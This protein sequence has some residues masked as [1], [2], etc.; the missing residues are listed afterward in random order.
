MAAS[1]SRQHTYVSKWATFS[2]TIIVMLSSG[3]NY[4]FSMW[5]G[6]VQQQMGYSSEQLAGLATACSIG[7]YLNILPG[8][9]YDSVRGHSRLGPRLTLAVGVL[10]QFG[11]FLGLWLAASNAF[12]PPYWVMWLMAVAACNCGPWF[13]TATM[14]TCVRNFEA[15][16]GIIISICKACLGLS[17]AFY[18]TLYQATYAPDA[19]NFILL[20]AMVPT[21]S[22]LL[23]LPFINYVPFVPVDST[24]SLG[25]FSIAYTSIGALVMYQLLDNLE[26]QQMPWR[27]HAWLR[28]PALAFLLLPILFIPWISGSIFLKGPAGST[29]EATENCNAEAGEC[30]SEEGHD[31]Y[32]D[33]EESVSQRQSWRAIDPDPQEPLL[34]AASEFA[35]DQTSFEGYQM[36]LL[37]KMQADLEASSRELF[38]RNKTPSQCL[39]STQ[40]WLLFFVHFIGSG[41]GFVLTSN[42]GQI[43]RALGPEAA[44]K[45]AIALSSFSAANAVG[46][47]CS[48]I[49]PEILTKYFKTPRAFTFVPNLVVIIVVNVGMTQATVGSLVYLYLLGGFACGVGMG[50]TPAV[51]ADC[52]G[53][54]NMASNYAMVQLG[55]ALS[56]YLLAQLLFGTFYRAASSGG[57]CRGHACFTSTFICM[58]VLSFIGLMSASMLC[59]KT[60]RLYHKLQAKDAM[61]RQRDSLKIHTFIQQDLLAKVDTDMAKM[62]SLFEGITTGLAELHTIAGAAGNVR[63]EMTERFR[64]RMQRV[65]QDVGEAKST[66]RRARML[67]SQYHGS[68]LAALLEFDVARN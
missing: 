42:L 51:A 33:I 4:T 15:D 41:T 65:Q 3:M 49:I 47:A 8:T 55:P 62:E 59:W 48:G 5:G 52:L 32:N 25:G 40:F 53:V 14:V 43:I 60:I 38:Q 66:L 50:L 36:P 63:T 20:L 31:A 68:G 39:V 17:A 24:P 18:T 58:A 22:V 23:C 54:R 12:N 56:S 13:E 1:G 29:N 44:A 11:G 61:Q 6:A 21:V 67:R 7:S 34:S 64:A 10:F 45:H 37:E 16:R 28:L 30:Q 35:Q 9:F 27:E 2:A 19:L 26:S 46:R 57:D